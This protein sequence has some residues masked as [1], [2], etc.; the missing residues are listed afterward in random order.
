MRIQMVWYLSTDGSQD[1][2]YLFV[3]VTWLPWGGQQWAVIGTV[4]TDTVAQDLQ[5]VTER[6]NFSDQG[7]NAPSY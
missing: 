2:D 5:S 1:P 6:G 3:M 4:D 7:I